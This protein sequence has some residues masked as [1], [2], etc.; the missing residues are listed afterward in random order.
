MIPGK[1][2]KPREEAEMTKSVKSFV[3]YGLGPLNYMT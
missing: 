2:T 1:V 3:L